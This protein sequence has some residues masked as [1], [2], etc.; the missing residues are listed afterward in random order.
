MAR[1]ER[2]MC[3][4][5][6]AADKLGVSRRSFVRLA[7]RAGIVPAVTNHTNLRNYFVADVTKLR[8]KINDEQKAIVDNNLRRLFT[9]V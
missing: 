9:D 1:R 5:T 2:K 8:K 3:T 6:E 4:S 7:D